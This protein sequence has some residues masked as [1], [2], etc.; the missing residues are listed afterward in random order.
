MMI[1]NS[2]KR[3]ILLFLFGLILGLESGAQESAENL[4][5]S[6]EKALKEIEYASRLLKET[7]GETN[8]SLG[9]INIINHRLKKRNEYVLGME[10]ERGLLSSMI[11]ENVKKASTLQHEIE[12][13]KKVYGSLILNLYKA[14]NPQYRLMYFLASENMNQLYKRIRMIRLYNAF[15]RSRKAKLE[16]LREE[17]MIRNGELEQL[18]RE[19]DELVKA[20]RME[21]KVIEQEMREKQRLVN[22]LKKKQKEIESEIREKEMTARKLENELKRIIEAERKKARA[23]GSK[24]IMTPAERLVSSDFEKNEGRLP[25]P[26]EKGIVTGQ[27]GEHQHPDYKSVIIRNDGIYITTTPGE[28]ARA[29]FKGI[30][31]RVFTIPGENY[32]VIIKHG[33]YYTLYHNLINVRVKAGQN[34]NTKE[35]IGTVFTNEKTR[36][37]VLYFQVWKETERKDPEL[38][39]AN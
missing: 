24:E 15:L 21:T 39:L 35:V 17:L 29:I 38:W 3:D 16:V 6:R 27:Y 23:S 12:K 9:E 26:T 10:L 19:K 36:E 1:M 11:E 31:S 7:Q 28:T 8:K 20:G 34:V 18:R 5:K 32:T 13:I 37:T 33:G 4:R 30:V 25:W 14:R 2:L 22:Q